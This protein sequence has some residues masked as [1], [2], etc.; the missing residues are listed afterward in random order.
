M[1]KLLETVSSCKEGRREIC[2]DRTCIPAI[3]AKTMKVSRVATEHAVTILW[4]VC[5]LFRD[6]K[7][8]E[9]VAMNNGLTK[10]LLVMQS[11]CQAGV[12]QMAVDLLKLF[13]V[14]SK[15][16][17]CSYDTKTTHIMPF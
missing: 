1:L 6:E 10:V 17:L 14:N 15:S 13:R 3:L 12:R 2:D 5:Y 16:L 4:S 8:Q 7:A 11:N 9:A